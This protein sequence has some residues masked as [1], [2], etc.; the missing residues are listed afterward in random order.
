MIIMS[1]S[2]NVKVWLIDPTIDNSARTEFRL[3]QGNLASSWKLVDVGVYNPLVTENE[4][5]VYYNSITGVL[6]NIAKLTVYSGAT[7]ID[8]IQ[9]LQSYGAVQSLRTTNQGSEDMSRFELLNGVNIAISTGEPLEY[10]ELNRQPPGCL[11]M[12]ASNKDYCNFYNTPLDGMLPVQPAPYHHNQFQIAT[13]QS[14]G[15]SGCLL[16]STYLKFLQSVPLLQ[17]IPDL[18]LIIE[19]NSSSE[20]LYYDPNSPSH[21]DFPAK[22]SHIRPQLYVEEILGLPISKEM[23]KLPFLS[24]IVERFVVPAVANGDSQAVSFRSGSL[25]QRFVKDLMFFNKVNSDKGWIKA[26][27]RSP[28]MKNETLQLVVDGKKYL[29][30]SG[31]TM[32][33]TKL[34]FFNDTFGGLNLPFLATMTSVVDKEN[35]YLN[36]ADQ[37]L[38]ALAGQF[39]VTG[40]LMNG[41]INQSLS[42]EVSRLGDNSV[43]D[44]Q[45]N[46]YTLLMYATVN[47]LLE[48]TPGGSIRLSY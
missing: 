10:D 20:Q 8:E 36:V 1:L 43:D 44:S 7:I 16:L 6:T 19:W 15:Q 41:V 13:N 2:N 11:T 37:D 5:G 40:V 17:N 39:S 32:P 27:T 48:Y 30:N 28:A 21:P 22:I 38:Y 4:T 35:D 18:R 45:V 42:I 12:N 34:Q 3:P 25:R 9:E 23:V 47:R 46:T 33:S 31:I 14:D 29:P 24:T 26:G